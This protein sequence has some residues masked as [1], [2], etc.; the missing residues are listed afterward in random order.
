M[1]AACPG[2]AVVDV[3]ASGAVWGAVWR[4]DGLLCVDG[5]CIRWT[6]KAAYKSI[7]NVFVYGCGVG[8][9]V[10]GVGVMRGRLCG[11]WWTW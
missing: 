10:P 3:Q 11:C 4:S 7:Y 8:A 1:V 2:V 5:T 9:M 6:C